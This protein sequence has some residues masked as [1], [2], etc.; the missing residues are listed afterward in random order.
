M[1]NGFYIFQVPFLFLNLLFQCDLSKKAMINHSKIYLNNFSTSIHLK[2]LSQF[3]TQ[4]SPN[5]Q[6]IDCGHCTIPYMAIQYNVCPN[7]VI[8]Y[9][10]H[11]A[12]SIIIY[13]NV[14]NVISFIT[15]NNY[16]LIFLIRKQL[17]NY[18]L[19]NIYGVYP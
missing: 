3:S 15:A 9:I 5:I 7:M 13:K 19:T 10:D 11:F 14:R 4:N 6:N 1:I 8:Q 16:R 12:H 2:I 18:E 17:I